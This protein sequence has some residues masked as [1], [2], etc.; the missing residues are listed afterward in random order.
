MPVI[1]AP[2]AFTVDDLYVDLHGIVG[3]HLHLK[4]EGLNLAGSIK[5]KAAAGMVDDAVA[6][7]L[8][9]PGQTL[10]ESSSGNLGV[11]LSMIAAHRGYR[12]VCVTDNRC[13]EPSVRMMR[14]LGAR[15]E[16]V[17]RPT[18]D[19]GLLGARL[20]RVREL[21]AA[22]DSYVWL[23]QYANEGNWRAHYAST[24]PQILK[25]FPDIDLLFVGAG[26]TGTL[27]GCAR[28]FRDE[29]LPVTVVAVDAVGSVTFGGN[30]ARRLIP[31]LGTSRRPEILDP[32]F[33]DDVVHVA[34]SDAIRACHRLA[35]HGFLFG[36]STGTVVAGALRWLAR[37]GGSEHQTAVLIAPDLGERY[38]GSVYD[39]NWLHTN[40][41]T[42]WT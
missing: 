1:S 9:R 15:V 37:N 34:E 25:Q 22:D 10:V 35:A 14:A 19:G 2:D 17:S 21:C 33:V 24:A 32:S 16:V 4:C 12:F 30:P 41:G 13:T 8:L 40:Y 38:L 27:M 26:T 7:G 6:S 23:N 39:E 18:A 36:G 11:A 31:G 28:F 20:D 29:G 5:L 42:E 3:H